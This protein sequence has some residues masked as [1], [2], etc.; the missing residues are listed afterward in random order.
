[1]N[2]HFSTLL[3]FLR[4]PRYL[5][6]LP[7]RLKSLLWNFSMPTPDDLDSLRRR[8]IKYEVTRETVVHFLDSAP[9]QSFA[10]SQPALFE[11][12]KN[13]VAAL[14]RSL[15]MGG[16]ADVDTLYTLVNAL[17]PARIL[18]TGVAHGWSTLALLA[19]S[20]R[21]DFKL[22]SVDLPYINSP[23]EALVGH[24]V[25]DQFRNKWILLRYPDSI[26][27]RIAMK[28]LG[29]FDV[30]HYDSDKSYAGKFRTLNYVYKK[31]ASSGII[32]V[33]DVNDNSAF[34]DFSELHSV[35]PMIY[36]FG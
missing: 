28:T 7:T 25:P 23:K 36:R 29:P 26:G 8:L 33:D 3:W 18:E 4:R 5:L 35:T 15:K 9:L 14:P 32:I 11:E 21:P 12:A 17:N 20:Q 30:F 13:R 2:R 1:M 10:T 24:L 16:G 6:H 22:V 31:L 27:I 34:L 19:G